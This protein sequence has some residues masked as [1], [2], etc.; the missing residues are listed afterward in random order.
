MSVEEARTEVA[1]YFKAQCVGCQV[2]PRVGY[3]HSCERD[4]ERADAYAL[5]LLDNAHDGHEPSV[6]ACAELRA[7]IEEAEA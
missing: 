7:R 5:A 6:C 1:A 4:L 3:A 2:H